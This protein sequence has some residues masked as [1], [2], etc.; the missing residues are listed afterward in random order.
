MGTGAQGGTRQINAKA[1]LMANIEATK[2]TFPLS[3]SGYFGHAGSNTGVREIHTKTPREDAKKMFHTL[4]QGAIIS[5][6]NNSNGKRAQ[7]E[8]GNNITY[9]RVSKSGSPAI[10]INIK[11]DLPGFK[12]RQKI[13]FIK[14]DS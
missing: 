12:T 7:F 8:A 11:I 6:L 9:R 10:D 2:A 13:H 14:E 5:D 3:P 4:S 1:Q